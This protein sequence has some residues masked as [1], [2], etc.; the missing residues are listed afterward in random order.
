MGQF[1]HTSRAFPHGRRHSRGRLGARSIGFA[2]FFKTFRAFPR[3]GWHSRGEIVAESNEFANF[4]TVIYKD[5]CLLRPTG[6][7]FNCSISHRYPYS[8]RAPR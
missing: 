7:F 6:R 1:L 5:F 3:C 2:N 4:F 8:S